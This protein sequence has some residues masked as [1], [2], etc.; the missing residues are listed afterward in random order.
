MTRGMFFKW[1]AAALGFGQE[2]VYTKTGENCRKLLCVKLTD[3]TELCTEKECGEGEDRC[4]LGHCQRSNIF[5]LGEP[6]KGAYVHSCIVC[7]VAYGLYPY[8]HNVSV[9]PS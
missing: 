9:T 2:G 7:G 8:L 5:Y 1:F 6:G 3:G 4:P